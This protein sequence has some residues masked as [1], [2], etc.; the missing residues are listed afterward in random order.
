MQQTEREPV[1]YPASA[2]HAD[3]PPT[4][5]AVLATN[6]PQ[7][8]SPRRREKNIQRSYLMR[9]GSKNNDVYMDS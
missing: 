3:V 6:A 7:V 2:H 9:T 1:N 8:L 4:I 5:N